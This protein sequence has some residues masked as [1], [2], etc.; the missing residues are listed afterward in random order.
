M[1][2]H[3]KICRTYAAVTAIEPALSEWVLK[4]IKSASAGRSDCPFT[5]RLTTVRRLLR[6]LEAHPAFVPNHFV[7]R[8]PPLPAGTPVPERSGQYRLGLAAGKSGGSSRSRGAR[9]PSPAGSAL[10]LARTA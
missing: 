5:G 6:W 9:T 3:D 7:N 4:A 8:R 1:H 10:P 2:P